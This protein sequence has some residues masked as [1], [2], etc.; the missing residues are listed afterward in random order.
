MGA[1]DVNGVRTDASRI[2]NAG[3]AMGLPVDRAQAVLPAE[4]IHDDEV[5]I[6]LL[7]PS[8]LFVVLSALGGLATVLVITL[9]LAYLARFTQQIGWIGWTDTQAFGLGA[10]LAALRMGWQTL[11]WWSRIYV[12][13]DRRIIRRMGVL[14]VS[15]FETEL[16]HVQHT[17]VFRRLRERLTGLG[18]IGFATAGSDVFDAFWTMVAQP[19]AVH[20]VVVETIRRSG[21]REYL[22]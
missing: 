4:L 19:F 17:S 13:T 18:S 3:E 14:R 22:D 11:E 1:P 8:P 5:V 21:S 7:R 16:R 12:L 15:V 6:L 9:L 20:R 2:L 10:A